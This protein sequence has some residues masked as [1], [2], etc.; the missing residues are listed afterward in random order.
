M[1]LGENFLY[2][3][4]EKLVR[5]VY[6]CYYLILIVNAICGSYQGFILGD[7]LVDNN[8]SKCLYMVFI[9]FQYFIVIL[10]VGIVIV[11]I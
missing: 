6:K 11:F 7:G 8:E 5:G 1:V 4:F 10:D 2:L 3:I 9:V